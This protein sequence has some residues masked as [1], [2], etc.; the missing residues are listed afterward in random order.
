LKEEIKDDLLMIEKWWLHEEEDLKLVGIYEEEERL[1][2][3]REYRKYLN[4]MVEAWKEC[5]RLQPGRMIER[6]GNMKLIYGSRSIDS[7][8]KYEW[9]FG[10]LAMTSH[11]I[12]ARYS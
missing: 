9:R 10:K 11:M 1:E 6:F 7:N 3:R 12:K 4:E 2:S 8:Y 5:Y